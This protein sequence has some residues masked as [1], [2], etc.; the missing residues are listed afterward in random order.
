MTLL[1]YAAE[2]EQKILSGKP[3]KKLY[4]EKTASVYLEFYENGDRSITYKL[5]AHDWE[6]IKELI[7]L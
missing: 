7:N 2:I 5:D 3:Y 6:K 1:Q 4:G